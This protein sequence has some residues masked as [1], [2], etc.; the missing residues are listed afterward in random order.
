MKTKWKLSDFWEQTL[1]CTLGTVIGIILTF[2]TSA[3]IEYREKQ[4]TERTAAMMV[5][6]NLDSFCEDLEESVKELQTI[7]SISMRVLTAK[8]RLETVSED[9][10]QCSSAVF[11]LTLS[12][13]M[14]KQPKPSSAAILK[15]GKASR[16]VNL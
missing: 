8:D 10:L 4:E 11:S 5:I 9:T 13:P 6:H 1:S 14:T 15:H 3:W 16:A 7:D 12:T 2:G